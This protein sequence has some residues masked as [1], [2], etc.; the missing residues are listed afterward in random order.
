VPSALTQSETCTQSKTNAKGY[1]QSHFTIDEHAA[2]LF[3]LET[4]SHVTTAQKLKI[5][6][7]SCIP[8]IRD[9]QITFPIEQSFSQQPS[10]KGG[11]RVA[12][13]EPKS[14]AAY[15]SNLNTANQELLNLHETNAHA[16]MQE[17]HY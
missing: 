8:L 13:L 3:H 17:M 12:I 6:T 2:T 15:T 5:P 7:I 16:D 9:I 11:K 10:N 14:L 1:N 4:L